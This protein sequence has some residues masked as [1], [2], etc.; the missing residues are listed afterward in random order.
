MSPKKLLIVDDS[1]MVRRSIAELFA[2]DGLFAVVGEAENGVEALHAVTQLKPDVITMDISMPGMDGL[3]AVKHIMIKSPTPI[4]M[5][6]SLTHEGAAVTF[7]ALRYGAVDIISKPSAVGN[8][9]GMDE[10]A[11]DIRSKI[12]FASDVEVEAIKYI[13][14]RL[15]ASATASEV[16]NAAPQ[17]V[18]ALGAAEGGY[19]A[20]LK[21]IPQLRAGSCSAYMVTLYASP[22]HI[23]AFASYLNRYS[24]LTVKVAEHDDVLRPGVC[25]LNAGSSYMSLHQYGSS[26]VLHV[27]PA[28]FASRKGSIDMMFF[29]VADVMEA[30][31][32]GVVLSGCG[33]DGTEGLE[34]VIRMGGRGIV[35]DQKTALSRGMIESACQLC[36]SAEL[37]ADRDIAS[38]LQNYKTHEQ[39]A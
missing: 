34:E 1:P 9:I 13:R 14:Q 16:P 39:G 33:V 20:L 23:E 12:E 29:S 22:S 32:V 36:L 24:D 35:Q 21:I 28:P 25:Y 26:L 27:S 8:H 37:M 7:D 6:S 15:P 38:F 5:I 2:G 17:R 19:G 3:T 4:V 18:V 31:S 11:A 10:Q 30:G